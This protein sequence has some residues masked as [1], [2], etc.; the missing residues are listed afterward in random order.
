MGGLAILRLN[1]LIMRNFRNYQEA[2]IS[3]NPQLNLILGD[4]AQGKTNLLEAIAYLSLGSSFREQGDDKLRK[5]G[6][7]FF[8]LRAE[9]SNKNGAHLLSVGSQSAHGNNGG[10]H[11]RRL[12]KR[13]DKPCRKVSEIAGLLHTV[14]FTPEDLQLVKSAPEVRRKFLDREMVQ[15]FNG[16]YLYL[17][18]YR[19]ALQQRNNLLKQLD[20]VQ[21][22]AAKAQTDEQLA[23]WEEQLA[24]NGAVIIKRRLQ[25]LQL[26]NE[27]GQKIQAELT[28]D[29]EQLRL[30]YLSVWPAAEIESCSLEELKEKLRQ[31]YLAG[32]AED[33]R[34][35]TTLHGPHRDDFRIYI[36]ETEGR[37][38]ASQ[39]QQRTA[40]LALKLSELELVWQLSG[41]YPLLLLD[42]VFSELDKNRRQ[43][44]LRLMLGKAQIFITAT[45]IA[46]EL[47]ALRPDDYQLF[48]VRHGSLNE[49]LK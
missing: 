19:R 4:N 33:K 39:G 22:P 38:Y 44:L 18:N 17:N 49:S 37:Y 31:K 47:Q 48:V 15:L 10:A 28:N 46:G 30:Q 34:R 32:R 29:R 9:Y 13:D 1:T 23:V 14:V 35:R 20:F 6:E 40:A 42:D 11:N 43:A 5:Q 7:E 12:W 3:F 26:L 27:T 45:E 24:E 8:F 2:K 16:Y 41:Y 21:S 36:N 25:L